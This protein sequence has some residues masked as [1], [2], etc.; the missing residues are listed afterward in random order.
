[1]SGNDYDLDFNKGL[2]F[3]GVYTAYSI[4]KTNEPQN[5]KMTCAQR[6]LG[7]AWVDLIGL[8]CALIGYLRSQCFFKRTAKTD[9]TGWMPRLIWVFAGCT[10]HFVGFVMLRLKYTVNDNGTPKK[11]K[12]IV[13]HGHTLFSLYFKQ[14]FGEWPKILYQEI[15][16]YYVIDICS[17]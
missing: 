12:T 17:S 8:R 16:P 3:S 1:M 13:W 2:L 11:E 4:R 14:S 5:T 9:Q 10:G 6:R 15:E 7:S